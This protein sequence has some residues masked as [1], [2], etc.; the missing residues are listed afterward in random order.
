M[1][2]AV[3]PRRQLLRGDRLCAVY[4]RQ[5]QVFPLQKLRQVFPQEL[6]IQKLAGQN[7][8]FLNFI[9]IK[10]GD[11]LFGGAVLFRAEPRFLQRV[12]FTVPEMPGR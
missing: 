7:G 12:Q 3:D 8:F 10:G 4:A 9:G 2:I 11:P 1:P 5:R 6:R